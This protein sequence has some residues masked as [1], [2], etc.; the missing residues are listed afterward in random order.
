MPPE[1]VPEPLDIP[2]VMWVSGGSSVVTPSDVAGP[3]GPGGRRPGARSLDLDDQG[4][5]APCVNPG[6]RKR[7]A[8]HET[9]PEHPRRQ[10][11][12]GEQQ[13]RLGHRR[14]GAL[15]DPV[16]TAA[17][18][19]RCPDEVVERHPG[20]DPR[21]HEA[22]ADSPPVPR[23]MGAAR[24]A[25][26]RASRADELVEGRAEDGGDPGEIQERRLQDPGLPSAHHGVAPSQPGGETSLAQ[27]RRQARGADA[28]TERLVRHRRRDERR[29]RP[30]ARSIYRTARRTRRNSARVRCSAGSRGSRRPSGRGRGRCG[31]S[32]GPW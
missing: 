22:V 17:I 20:L 21:S 14:I 18:H 4:R 31:G 2:A 16:E 19:A 5:G 10:P 26:P 15:L 24:P 9:A 8:E 30:P 12:G 13:A 3:E 7:P 29:R 23:P 11:E 27:A 6:G 28:G 25:A 32:R 1:V